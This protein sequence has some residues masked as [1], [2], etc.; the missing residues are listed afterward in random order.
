M[1]VCGGTSCIRR[2]IMISSSR[3]F[4]P[5]PIRLYILGTSTI[6]HQRR[7]NTTHMTQSNNRFFDEFAKL[8]TDAAGAAQG[9][10]REAET[11]MKSQGER[12]L[13]GMDLVQR[14][15]FDAVKAMAAKA[16][17]ENETLAA[18]IAVLEAELAALK[19]AR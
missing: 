2:D 17:E 12:M 11:L 5:A 7:W 16:R 14:E 4:T 10:R 8:M 6:W 9:L 1:V 3:D 19:A 13:A 15:E 18:R